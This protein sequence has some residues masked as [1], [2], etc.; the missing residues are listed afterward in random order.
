MTAA[1][2]A[3]AIAGMAIMAGASACGSGSDG[4]T[5]GS[6]VTNKQASAHTSPA[7][8]QCTPAVMVVRHAEDQ[9]NPKGGADILSPAG[10]QHAKLYPQLF[11]KYLA[12]P[13]AI[14][15]G[16]ADVT[17]CPIGKVIAINP[18]SNP[19]NLSPGTNPFETIK[20]VVA[21]PD[22]IKVMDA[23]GVSYSTVYN[24]TA[25]RRETLLQNG[26]PTATSTVIA[27]DKQGMNPSA[28]DLDKKI[29]NKTLRSYGYVPLLQA[30]PTDP[31]AIV[32]SDPLTYTPQRTDFYVFTL[33]DPNTGTFGSAKAYQ[34]CFSN[35][36]GN[37]WYYT[38]FLE[39]DKADAIKT[40]TPKTNPVC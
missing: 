30:L 40:R 31:H 24:W 2:T 34:Q 37:T 25:A 17:V 28:A 12:T 36:G 19:Q 7:A 15:P 10:I 26:T 3:A 23:D 20:H 18:K 9:K 39:S 33:Q 22:T 11:E 16:G 13:H 38:T 21:N 32:G 14:G 35:D 5:S 1:R 29:N 27:W 4:S 8:E 6:S